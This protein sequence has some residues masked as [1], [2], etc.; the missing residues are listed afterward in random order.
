MLDDLIGGL[1]FNES[2]AAGSA[3]AAAPDAPA[4]GTDSGSGDA[5]DSD[6]DPG[7]ADEAADAAWGHSLAGALR[8]ADPQTPM[9]ALACSPAMAA[10][11]QQHDVP[12]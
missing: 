10:H 11:Q 7:S 8:V 5:A 4:G 12:G 2:E 9:Q 6:G 3:A 1:L